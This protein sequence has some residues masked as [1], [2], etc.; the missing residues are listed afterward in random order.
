MEG[1]YHVYLFGD[2]TGDFE[3]GLRRLLQA[4]NHTFV[5]AF[6][7]RS[8]HALR[9]EIAS[10]PP[11]ERSMFPR[12]T[13]IVDLLARHCESRGNSAMESALT[14]IYQLGCFIKYVTT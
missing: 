2:Q 1:S 14:C 3:T 9:Q 10:L 4:K 11:A 13:S 6:F 8:Y 7:Q 5:S 12:F